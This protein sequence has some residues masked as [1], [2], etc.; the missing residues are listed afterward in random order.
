MCIYI[1]MYMSMHIR[2]R[3]DTYQYKNEV[4]EGQLACAHLLVHTL[5]CR[6]L[7]VEKATSCT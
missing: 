7:C 6:E 2:I 1:Y 3:I 4:N 5:V